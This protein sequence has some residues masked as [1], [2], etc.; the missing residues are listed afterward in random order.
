MANLMVVAVCLLSLGA[1]PAP[2]AGEVTALR[3]AGMASAGAFDMLARLTALGPR[4]A[5]SGGADE[6]VALT[7]SLMQDLGLDNIHLEPVTVAHWVRG[8][9][10]E[11]VIHSAGRTVPLSVCALGGSVRTAA[12]GIR[13]RVMEVHDFEE[14][15]RRQQEA[16]GRMVFFNRPMDPTHLDTFES[17][18]GAAD[19]RVYG[20]SRA[21]KFGAVAVLV[22]S[23]TMKHD[24]VP[25]TG[26]M[27]YEDKD[28]IPAAAL[29]LKSADRLSA[30]LKEDPELEVFLEQ[31][32]RFE[33]PVESYNVTGQITGTEKP[34]EIIVIGGHLDAWDVG[35]GAHDDGAGCVQ[36]IEA[37]RLLKQIG[38]KPRRTIR[39][40]M[41]MDEEFGGT[42]GRAYAA[43][44]R[45]KVEKHV[46]AIESD[47]GGFV[48]TG[49]TVRGDE[50]QVAFVR[51]W[52]PALSKAGVFFVDEGY[53][54]VDINPLAEGG[55]LTIGLIV[56]SQRYFDVHHSANDSLDAV[57]PRE[58]ELGAVA[59]A[60]LAYILSEE[61]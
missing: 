55:T 40:V 46:A 31:D 50:K 39:A 9:P 22:R 28:K 33:Q 24:D 5:G 52:M 34:G 17:Y 60:A 14:L 48:P 61:F 3:K 42:G 26:I 51:Q 8:E 45:R 29:G 18:G 54:G 10:E 41:F 37:L 59:M 53:G 19:Q 32:C 6:A 1:D 11:G 56:D 15:E 20:A 38:L 25:H 35:A 7:Q 12:N 23:L 43:D 4:L 57:N 2:Y 49:F 13:A 58:L 27:L 30:M 21:A 44:K 47:R 16:K 36:A